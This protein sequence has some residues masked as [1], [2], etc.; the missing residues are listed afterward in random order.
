MKRGIN[1]LATDLNLT[2]PRF[3]YRK[4]YNIITDG[5]DYNTNAAVLTGEH[6]AARMDAMLILSR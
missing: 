3:Q 4:V 2:V 5:H 6:Y 1:S